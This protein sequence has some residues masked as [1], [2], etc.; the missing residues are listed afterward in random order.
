MQYSVINHQQ[1]VSQPSEPTKPSSLSFDFAD[2]PLPPEWKETI[3]NNLNAMPEVFAQHDLDFGRTYKVKH[4][5]KLSDETQFKQ[6]YSPT[7]C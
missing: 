2:S 4:H 7:K 5:I 3:I 1:S 6:T